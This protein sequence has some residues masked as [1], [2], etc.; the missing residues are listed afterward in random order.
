MLCLLGWRGPSRLGRGERSSSKYQVF[1][2]LS[3]DAKFT[4]VV[5]FQHGSLCWIHKRKT[6]ALSLYENCYC[7][8]CSVFHTLWRHHPVVKLLSGTFL[9]F[10]CLDRRKIKHCFG[11]ACSHITCV[12]ASVN[13]GPPGIRGARG[14]KVNTSLFPFLCVIMLTASPEHTVHVK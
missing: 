3:A 9:P 11:S 2:V 12:C 4:L 1:L 14:E 10:C 5:P 8:I 13:Q 6:Q 7:Q